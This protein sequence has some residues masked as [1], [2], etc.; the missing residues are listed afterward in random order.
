MR[1]DE[2]PNALVDM[3]AEDGFNRIAF[4]DRR[5]PFY[6]SSATLTT[7]A[8]DQTYTLA[9]LSLREIKRIVRSGE[10]GLMPI[11]HAEAVG[12]FGTD[13]GDPTHWS[14]LSDVVYLWPIPTSTES[15]TVVGWREPTAWYNDVSTEIDAHESL[16]LSVLYWVLSKAYAQLEDTEMAAFYE[17]MFVSG[18][19]GAQRALKLRNAGD[20]PLIYSGGVPSSPASTDVPRVL[21]S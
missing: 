8:A 9:S 7:S 15:L 20:L 17:G 5:W 3:F 14:M 6:Q 11:D 12:W 10:G 16:H 13:T 2:F 19:E 21:I 4:S 1:E 18:V